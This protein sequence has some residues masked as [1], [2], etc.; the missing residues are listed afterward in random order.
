MLLVP[1]TAAA[2][3][4]CFGFPVLSLLVACFVH[5]VILF[6]FVTY[7]SGGGTTPPLK[8]YYSYFIKSYFEVFV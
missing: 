6:S 5:V 4:L 3:L 2:L 7:I 1:Q 8:F